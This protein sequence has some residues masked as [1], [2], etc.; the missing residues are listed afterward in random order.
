M[1]LD[2]IKAILDLL[3][4]SSGKRNGLADAIEQLRKRI[5][6]M[7]GKSSWTL[8]QQQNAVDAIQIL[9]KQVVDLG[10]VPAA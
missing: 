10:G 4:A 5:A 1:D 9:R 6:I 8:Q 2:T 3:L 7:E